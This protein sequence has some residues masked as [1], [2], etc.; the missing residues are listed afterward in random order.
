MAA[1]HTLPADFTLG[2]VVP[3]PKGGLA[4]CPGNVQPNTLQNTEYKILARILATRFGYALQ[5]CAG[6]HQPAF[7]QGREIGDSI[8]AVELLGCALAAEQ[9]P[10]AAVILDIAKA[11]DTLDRSFLFRIMAAAGR[12]MVRWFQLLLSD[13]RAYTIVHGHV[14]K[15]Q[16]WQA[17]VRQGCP[18]SLLLYLQCRRHWP[19]GLG[20][21]RSWASW[22]PISGTLAYTMPTIQR[23]F[24]PPYNRNWCRAWSCA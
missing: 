19:A 11:Y 12:P 23:S 24:C 15:A 20:S 18:L 3:L 10:G 1:C 22:W 9:L 17:G 5:L 7:L 16:T 6:P 2:R 4:S 13:T 8:F 21:A 14:S